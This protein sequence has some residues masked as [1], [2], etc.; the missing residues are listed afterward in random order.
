V[1]LK[2]LQIKTFTLLLSFSFLNFL[3]SETFSER[4]SSL[5]LLAEQI[6]YVPEST[7]SEYSYYE[8][9]KTRAWLRYSKQESPQ[10]SEYNGYV[11]FAD[12]FHEGQKK[13][14]FLLG[15]DCS[16]FTHRVYQLLGADYPLAKTRYF[17]AMAK[18]EEKPEGLSLCAWNEL[19][20]KFKKVEAMDLHVG[21]LVVYGT[22][23]D[24]FGER[25]HMGIVSSL[26]P[27]SVIQSKYRKGYFTEE[28][29]LEDFVKE[30]KPYF[31]RYQSEL[32]P[33]DTREL[34]EL[35]GKNYPFNNSGCA[36][37]SP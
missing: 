18:G 3:Y 5:N 13:I 29:N 27:F 31:F 20:N 28:L 15:S 10:E 16:N 32:R 14:S 1:H 37:I 34:K 7:S 36:S 6:F 26:K 2:K 25:G 17:I 22:T 30:K 23:L 9:G 4:F 35:L 12:P 33:L 24:D 19:H 21:D 8:A 11:L